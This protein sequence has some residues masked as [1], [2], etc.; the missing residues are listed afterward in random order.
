MTLSPTVFSWDVTRTGPQSWLWLTRA[1][2]APVLWKLPDSIQAS[3][4]QSKPGCD[5]EAWLGP[6]DA[7]GPNLA[8][9]LLVPLV[10]L[11][12][13]ASVYP[14]NT[15]LMPSVSCPPRLSRVTP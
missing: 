11:R 15:S 4:V 9:P 10:R 8:K 12:P 3:G 7:P 1:G 13:D 2:L 6:V 5:R 14:A